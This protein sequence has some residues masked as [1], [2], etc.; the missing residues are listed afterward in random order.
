MCRAR[1]R[2]YAAEPDRSGCSLFVRTQPHLSLTLARRRKGVFVTER[3][4]K[5]TLIG[6]VPSAARDKPR[7]GSAVASR[8]KRLYPITT[9]TQ[10]AH[11]KAPK[12]LAQ[13][14]SLEGST[15]FV[16]VARA[17]LGVVW[18]S[19]Q[20]PRRSRR[21]RRRGSAGQT[22]AQKPADGTSKSAPG[23]CAIT[24][25]FGAPVRCRLACRLLAGRVECPAQR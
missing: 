5:P 1:D 11:S 24:P 17:G 19:R 20:D 16:D 3:A 7:H 10:R 25:L 6:A 15:L 18:R 23:V 13:S 4:T 2:R 8:R 14:R 9:R 12:D 21:S 22:S